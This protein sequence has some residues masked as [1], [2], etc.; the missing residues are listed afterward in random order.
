M[1]HA[2]FA[3]ARAA[4]TPWTSLNYGADYLFAH[5][6]GRCTSTGK[7]VEISQVACPDPRALFD[8][9]YAEQPPTEP[10]LDR[11]IGVLA[12]PFTPDD[13][14]IKWRSMLNAWSSWKP[15]AR[16]VARD[17]RTDK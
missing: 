8:A 6:I 1:R 16:V 7:L 15:S 3:T 5:V 12:K 11:D 13:L 4:A 10:I 2:Q 17:W 9:G 14:G